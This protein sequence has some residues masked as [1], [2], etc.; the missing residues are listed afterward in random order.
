MLRKLLKYDMKAVFRVWWILAV[1]VLGVSI[2]GSF[3]M[4]FLFEHEDRMQDSALF[5]TGF[6]LFMVAAIFFIIASAI[7][8][9]L[10][11][12]LRFYRNLFTD[13]GYLTF[14]L[15][16]S[17]GTLFAAKTANAVIWS[18][19]QMLLY[20][21]CLLIFF[22]IAP[23]PEKGEGFFNLFIFEGL[24]D[25][26]S[27]IWKEVGA[28]LLVYIVEALLIL[29]VLSVYSASLVHFCITVGS[30][31]AK[32][33]K[34]LAAIGVYYAVTMVLNTAT[35]V[36]RTIFVFSYSGGFYDL[37]DELPEA[38]YEPTFALMLGAVVTVCAALACVMYCVT[39]NT[40]ERKLNLP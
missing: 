25:V 9:W 8:T 5:M 1:S 32:K 29:L 27:D 31:L 20:G 4:R 24:A 36:L 18:A 13:E 21:V 15:P 11:I 17:R 37:L 28:W 34:L 10:L 39:Q 2:A 33:H 22:L 6:S 26:V 38:M 7:V 35:Q 14:T 40:L 23:P 12:Y 16:V 30:I 19:M 3:V